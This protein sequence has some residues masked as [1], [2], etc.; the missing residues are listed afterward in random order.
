MHNVNLSV[1][2]IFLICS[3]LLLPQAKCSAVTGDM[4]NRE[5]QNLIEVLNQNDDREGFPD[6]MVGGG[7]R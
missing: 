2:S 4:A 1:F 3:T 7:T 6:D 5:D